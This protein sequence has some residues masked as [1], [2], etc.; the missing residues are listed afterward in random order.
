MNASSS[1]PGTYGG[2][3]GPPLSMG[4]SSARGGGSTYNQGF[5]SNDMNSYGGGSHGLG[6]GA[7]KVYNP[8]GD[9]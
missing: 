5:G 2:G 6:S 8:Y 4:S 7:Q 3:G 1:M 9:N